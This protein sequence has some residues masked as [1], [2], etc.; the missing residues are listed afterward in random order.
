M[1]R[2]RS[3]E[4]GSTKDEEDGVGTRLSRVEEDRRSTAMVKV[5]KSLS[6]GAQRVRANDTPHVRAREGRRAGMDPSRPCQHDNCLSGDAC[7]GGEQ[8]RAQRGW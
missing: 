3:I 6:A 1:C 7:R 2:R 5:S 8:R 4:T